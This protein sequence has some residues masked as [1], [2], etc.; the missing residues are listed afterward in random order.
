MLK[1]YKTGLAQLLGSIKLAI[2]FSS[3]IAY[4]CNL[5]GNVGGQF[6]G[7]AQE[8]VGLFAGLYEVPPCTVTVEGNVLTLRLEQENNRMTLTD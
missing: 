5:F 8:I 6:L 7:S 1:K 3:Y 2:Y 4:G